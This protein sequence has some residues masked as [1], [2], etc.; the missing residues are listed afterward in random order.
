MIHETSIVAVRIPPST[1]V[2]AWTHIREGARIGSECVIGERVY[3]DHDVFIGDRCK[4]GNN[5]QIYYPAAIGN[6]V[7]IGPGAV[8]AND[9]H[10]RACN[11]D[12][13]LKGPGDWKCEG[14]RV[15]NGASI[16][17]NTT[18]IGGVTIWDG[19][20]V[21]AGAVVTRDVPPGETWKGVPAK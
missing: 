2:W 3:I 19:A 7:F 5:A 1:K 10:P 8:L 21:G 11:Y 18:I 13:S 20:I 16:G 6:G 15:A 9:R 17:A 12:G 14:V 4:I